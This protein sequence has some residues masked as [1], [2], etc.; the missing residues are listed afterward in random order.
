[1][2]DELGKYMHCGAFGVQAGAGDGNPCMFKHPNRHMVTTS[3]WHGFPA[4]SQKTGNG[5]WGNPKYPNIDYADVHAYISTSPAPTADRLLMEKDAAYYHLWHSR[6]YGAW[7]LKLPIV[8]G[9]AG[10]VP[11]DGSTDDKT[12][13]GLQRDLL[14]IWYHNYLWSSLDGGALYEIYWYADPHVYLKGVYDHRHVALSL[15][16]FM[17]GIALNNGKYRDLEA[18]IS[19]PDLRVVGQKDTVSGNAHLWIQNKNF[20]WKNAVEEIKPVPVSGTVRIGGFVFD[21]EYELEYWDTTKI[22]DQ[23]TATVTAKAS[24]GGELTIPV[25]SLATDVAL[26]IWDKAGRR[27]GPPRNVRFQ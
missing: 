6:Q 24:A 17:S 1:M 16:N 13:L 11:Y 19:N 3:F 25:E 26:K 21:K 15:Y 27:P 20:T 23:I 2:A 14:G 18:A 4:Y 9:E 22:A 10:M 12:G 8:R 7:N 5:F